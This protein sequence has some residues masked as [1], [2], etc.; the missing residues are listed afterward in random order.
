MKRFVKMPVERCSVTGCAYVTNDYPVR[1]ALDA[2]RLHCRGAHPDAFNNGGGGNAG[3]LIDAQRREKPKRPALHVPAEGTCEPQDWEYFVQCRNSYKTMC[4]INADN[5]NVFF[6]DALPD[7][8]C[9][10]LHSNYGAGVAALTEEALIETTMNLVVVAKSRFA[11]IV[12]LEGMRQEHDERAEAFLARLKN[13]VR[14]IGLKK[15]RHCG[16][17]PGTDVEID[18]SEDI[19]LNKFIAGLLDDE[20]KEDLMKATDLTLATAS[21]LVI[22]HEMAKRSRAMNHQFALVSQLNTKIPPCCH[23]IYFRFSP[24]FVVSYIFLE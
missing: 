17:D 16:C 23:F 8:V 1:D 9:R 12:E 24:L 6:R 2:L 18:Y 5:A 15:S 11:Y 20:I 21:N 22:T 4:N 13:K 7:D 19:V 14:Q 10:M 3:A